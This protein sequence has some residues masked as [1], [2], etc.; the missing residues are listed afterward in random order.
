MLHATTVADDAAC[1]PGHAY[2][3]AL[4][5]RSSRTASIKPGRTSTPCAL[6]HGA[7]EWC[8]RRASASA[9][10]PESLNTHTACMHAWWRCKAARRAERSVFTVVPTSPAE[11][12]LDK[13]RLIGTAMPELAGVR[14]GAVAGHG[15]SLEGVW[16]HQGLRISPFFFHSQEHAVI[17]RQYPVEYIP[18]FYQYSMVLYC[19]Y[20]ILQ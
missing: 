6:S 19:I 15:R 18:V 11:T 8:G 4:A 3:A 10:T 16:R 20:C 2:R 13:R 14:R 9:L 7:S 1:E 17:R 5:C 12:T